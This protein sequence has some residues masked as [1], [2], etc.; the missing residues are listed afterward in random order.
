MAT[1]KKK[2]ESNV[3]E[4]KGDVSPAE[5]NGLAEK[6]QAA[7]AEFPVVVLDLEGVQ[8][9]HTMTAQ[10]ILCAKT[11][12]ESVGKELQLRSPS[13]A[14]REHCMKIGLDSLAS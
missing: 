6:L 9:C 4:L 1:K 5:T 10:L 12:A 13:D 7:L 8:S 11:S 14:W 2:Q 3:I